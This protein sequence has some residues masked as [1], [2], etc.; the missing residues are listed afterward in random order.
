M[1]EL[2]HETPSESELGAYLQEH[3]AGSVFACFEMP[4]EQLARRFSGDVARF[5]EALGRMDGLQ[6]AHL[7]FNAV[8]AGLTRMNSLPRNHPFWRNTNCRPTVYKLSEFCRLAL[9]EDSSNSEALLAA[10][11]L[12]AWFG[13]NDFGQDFWLRL[14]HQIGFDI[15]WPIYAALTT[16]VNASPTIEQTVQFL[17]DCDAERSSLPILRRIAAE[18]DGLAVSGARQVLCRIDD[19]ENG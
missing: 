4:T 10:A 12:P 15:R 9:A 13:S 14:R 1:P 18:G 16:D 2:K 3:F 17:R 6:F 11:I 5:F 19:L 7:A 8:M